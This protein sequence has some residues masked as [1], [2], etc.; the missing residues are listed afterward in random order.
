MRSTLSSFAVLSG[1]ALILL[2]SG[3]SG[4]LP[5]TLPSTTPDTLTALQAPQSMVSS[6]SRSAASASESSG[7]ASVAQSAADPGESP[8]SAP[9]ESTLGAPAPIRAPASVMRVWVAPWEDADG[10]LHGANHL[11]IEVLPRRWQLDGAVLP[12]AGVLQPLQIA[13]RSQPDRP[14]NRR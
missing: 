6:R 12:A 7:Q 3:C 1:S 9:S 13:E 10:T 11:Y 8:T 4:S 14:N 2:L 5:K